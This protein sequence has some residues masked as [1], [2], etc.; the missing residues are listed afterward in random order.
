M[1]QRPNWKLWLRRWDAQQEMFNPDRELRF[2]VMFDI[3]ASVIRG[4]V[5][6]L[7]LGA[8]PGS[9]SARF[10]RRFPRGRCTAVDYDPVVLRVGRGA[11][12]T[13]H[14]RLEWVD[15][16][17]ADPFWTKRLTLHRYNVALSTTALHWLR[18][19]EL[20]RLFRQ[21]RQVLRPGGLFLNGDFIPWASRHAGLTGVSDR[22]LRWKLGP[23]RATGE[24]KCWNEWWKN[25]GLE[26][27]LAP[28]FAERARRGVTHPRG[29]TAVPVDG[30]VRQLSQAGFRDAGVIWDHFQ[31]RIVLAIR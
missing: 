12:G 23:K 11:L 24:W 14:G 2:Q 31:D 7:D 18:R 6:A 10:L 25:I 17:L 21:V 28:Q 30:Y 4:P 1:N 15:A 29:R 9:L 22:V 16:N 3:V 19:P 26:R 5:R 27:S 20:L 8:G 13:M